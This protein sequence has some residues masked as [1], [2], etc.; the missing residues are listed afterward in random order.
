MFNKNYAYF[1][2]NNTRHA[3]HKNSAPGRVFCFYRMIF[4]KK[5]KTFEQQISLLKSRGLK[6]EDEKRAMHILSNISY[7][8]LSAYL[9]T[10]QKY[11]D[12]DH[13][14][15]QWASFE[16]VVTLYAFDR[17]LR[18][19]LLDS[20]ERIEVAIRCRIVYSF[21]HTYGNNWYENSSLFNQGKH[22]KFLKTLDNEIEKSNELF[23]VH[24]KSKYTTPARPPAWMAMEVLSFGQLSHMFKNLAKTSAKKEV[25]NYFGLSPTLLESWMEHV[26]YIRNLC[27][28]HSRVWNRV[29]TVTAAF[30]STPI[31]YKWINTIPSRKDKLYFSLCII[32]Y[33]LNRVSSWPTFTGEIKVLLK[34]FHNIDIKAAGFPN[35]WQND[36]F[37]K[38]T[39][40]PLT[41]KLRILVFS[42]RNRIR[43]HRHAI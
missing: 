31:S 38:T 6:I 32:A 41:H 12:P 3:T 20:I 30:P 40:F 24:Y 35:N 9:L 27:A 21:C 28:H 8:R 5:A 26:V 33:L 36:N 2:L 16:K 15:M 23:I 42:I 4:P 34:R 37:W 39:P 19:V 43:E 18:G 14:F 7:Y 22:G 17:Q 10:F 1:C 29:M 11:N 25:A 13:S